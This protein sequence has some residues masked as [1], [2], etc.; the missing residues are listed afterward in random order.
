MKDMIISKTGGIKFP[1]AEKGKKRTAINKKILL[2]NTAFRIHGFL[3]Y[4]LSKLVAKFEKNFP[5]FLYKEND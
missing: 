1:T 3:M 5:V 4:Q 2:R